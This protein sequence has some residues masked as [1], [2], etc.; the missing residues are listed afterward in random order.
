MPKLTVKGIGEFDVQAGKR[1]V[2]ALIEDAGTDQLHA[3]GGNA[4]CTKRKSKPTRLL[5]GKRNIKSSRSH[6]VRRAFELPNRL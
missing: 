4:R 6:R 2:N 3:C 1:L 5:S